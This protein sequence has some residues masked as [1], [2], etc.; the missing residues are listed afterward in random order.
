M[1][2]NQAYL[3]GFSLFRKECLQVLRPSGSPDGSDGSPSVSVWL[4]QPLDSGA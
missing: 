2:P 3:K 4:P 1:L